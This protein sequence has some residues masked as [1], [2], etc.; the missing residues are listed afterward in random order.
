LSAGDEKFLRDLAETRSFTLGKPQKFAF[1]PDGSWVVFLRAEPRKPR[2]HLLAMSVASGELRELITPEQVLGREG[3]EQ[4]SPEERARRE[5]MRITDQGFAG[6]DLSEDGKVLL[7][8]LSGR[9]FAVELATGK[10]VEVA[11]PDESKRAPFDAH[12]SP[13]GQQVAFV[14]GGELWVAPV[15][16]GKAKQLTQGAGGPISHAQAE[17][18]AQEEMGRFTG[19]WWI[20]PGQQLLYEIA[21][22]TGV[23]QLHLLDPVNPFANLTSQPY[24]RPGKANV[25]VTLAIISA[26]GGQSRLVQWDVEKYPYLARVHSME[27]APLTIQV[28]TRDQRDLLL[29][30]VDPITGKTKQ[31]LHEHDP[32]WINLSNE[33][34]WLPGGGAFLWP[35]ERNGFWQLELRSRDGKLIRE[36]TPRELDVRHLRFVDPTSRAIIVAAGREPTEQHLFEMPIGGGRAEQLT[37]NPGFHDGIFA[38][39]SRVHVHSIARID[40]PQIQRL[41]RAD[42]SVAGE[43]PSI[44]EQPPREPKVQLAKVGEKPGFWTALVRPRDFDPKGKYPVWLRVYGGPGH[45]V[46]TPGAEAYFFDQWIAD[47]GYIVAAIDNRGTEMR[48]RDWNRAIQYKFA[49]VPLEDQVAGLKALSEI[50]PAMDL[51]RVG[52][53]GGSFGGYL[54]AL[55]VMRRPDVFRAAVALAPVSEWL[56]YDTYYTERYLGIPGKDDQ[57]YPANSLPQYAPGLSR[58]LLLMHGTADDNVHFLHTLKLA[59]A[60]FRSSR[61]F[62]LLPLA[63]QTHQLG[64]DAKVRL[65]L[66][67]RMFNFFQQS[68]AENR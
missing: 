4:L 24:P 68:L 49:E 66:W 67:R 10:S 40:G 52:V 63:G 28:Q 29:L 57:I 33:Y 1:T 54:S 42:G 34:H 25:A 43:M 59:D 50:E 41:V 58:S 45:N 51:G 46:V 15:A 37:S 35:T 55:A 56:D 36:L 60:L 65:Q 53:S 20:R 32:A 17:F 6:F 7:T 13:D 39:A 16:G 5:R 30:E 44:A 19:H 22:A 47:H 3:A 2:Q 12:L 14:R 21:D 48:G 62:Q 11:G 18:V 27:D 38:K 61:A 8:S 26:S 31:L 9:I 23:E 64:A